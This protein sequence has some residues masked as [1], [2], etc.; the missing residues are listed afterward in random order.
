M[1]SHGVLAQQGHAVAGAQ[2]PSPPSE[3]VRRFAGLIPV[4][5]KVLDLA[6]GT[7]RHSRL[8]RDSG[9][10]VLAVDRDPAL[11]QVLAAEGLVT[12]EVDL[13]SGAQGF[14]WP[15]ADQ[16]FDAIVVTNYL[17]RPL[18]PHMLASLAP[19]GLLIYETF[20]IGNAAYGRPANP[21]FLLA[22]AELLLQMQSNPAVKMHVLAYEHGYVERPKPAVVQR[23]CARKA[24]AG[25]GNDRL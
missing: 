17:H 18:F 1:A 19:D 24:A 8:L 4:G 10:E 13:E 23:I 3:W 2:A 11:L 6:C 22:D 7:G 12:Q 21:D 25:S 20:A 16:V 5:G 9:L 15:F 14:Y